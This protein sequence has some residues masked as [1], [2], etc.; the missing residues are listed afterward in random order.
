M[1]IL[2]LL[3]SL[4]VACSTAELLIGLLSGRAGLVSD[5][6]HLTFD[7]GLLTF[8]LFAMA[9]SWTKANGS[10]LIE[11]NA[12]IIALLQQAELLNSLAL[13]VTIEKTEESYENPC[14]A[15][16]DFF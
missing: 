12:L 5:A 9:A 13:K 3:I 4:N 15:V 14:K 6:F 11:T 1:D 7:C 8:S 2:V 10:T 16:E